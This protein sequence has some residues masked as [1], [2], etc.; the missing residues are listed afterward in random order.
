MVVQMSF[1]LF[2]A[3]QSKCTTYLYMCTDNNSLVILY[4]AFHACPELIYIL[5]A[6][7]RVVL[8]SDI[9]YLMHYA[10]GFLF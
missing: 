9:Y 10:G 8:I 4:L 6:T 5:D 3:V 7:R 2:M 1:H